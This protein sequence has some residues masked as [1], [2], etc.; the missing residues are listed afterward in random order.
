MVVITP[1]A[2]WYGFTFYLLVIAALLLF[3]KVPVGYV[4]RRSL[5]ILPFVGIVAVSLPFIKQGEVIGSLNI[6]LWHI[7]ITLTG[8]EIFA[9]IMAKAWLSALSL[10]LLISTTRV[11][12]LLKGL[13]QL[14]MPLILIM[15]ISF[16]YRYI[17]VLT[18]DVM[19][20]KQ[21]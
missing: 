21:A 18:D 16:M 14:R 15:I 11:N 4:L 6:W 10:I 13:E 17:F 9:T 19:R 20:L 8:L 2:Q 3:S 1:V 5:L 7:Q 12:D